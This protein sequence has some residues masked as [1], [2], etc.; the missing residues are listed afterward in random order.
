V[1]VWDPQTE[2]QLDCFKGDRIPDYRA[3]EALSPYVCRALPTETRIE[4]RRGETPVAWFEVSGYMGLIQAPSGNP[5]WAA[6]SGRS[7]LVFTLEDAPG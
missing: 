1:R 3:S 2:D 4:H 6:S 7:L 5:V